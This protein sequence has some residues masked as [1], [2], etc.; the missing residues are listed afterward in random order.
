[1][2]WTPKGG[3]LS[4]RGDLVDAEHV[5][6]PATFEE[7]VAAG[8]SV[9]LVGW[10]FSWFAGRA[11]EQRPSWGY[12]RMLVPRIANAEAVLDVQTGGGEVLA[13]VLARV[14][15]RPRFLAATESWPPN[16]ELANAHLRPFG[17]SVVEVDDENSLPFPDGSFDLVASRHPTYP[18]SDE[19]AR[20]LRPGGT[21]FSQ[22]V[23]AGS[24][25]EL[26]DFMMGPQPVGQARRAER[27]VAEAEAAGLQVVD[28]RQATLQT[29]FNDIGAVV[30]FLRKVLW[31]VPGFTVDGYRVQLLRLHERIQREGPFVAH[32]QRFLIEATKPT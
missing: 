21:Y 16:V 7:L 6:V 20:V 32:A 3:G 15:Q 31:T 13:E 14:S 4:E 17:A 12:S 24:N 22:Q 10:D 2:P 23:G 5:D 18:L 19:I 29:V 1:M 25:R 11:T 26:T 27:A 30:H 9:P 28:L 8:D